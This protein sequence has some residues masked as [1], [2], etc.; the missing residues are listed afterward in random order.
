[1]KKILKISKLICCF[2]LLFMLTILLVPEKAANA[3][4]VEMQ[5]ISYQDILKMSTAMDM[6][7]DSEFYDFG[8]NPYR[9]FDVENKEFYKLF[10][11]PLIS[12]FR[13]ISF[14]GKSK[15]DISLMYNSEREHNTGL[16]VDIP[17]YEVKGNI[18][19]NFK[20]NIASDITTINEEY[21]EYF[22]RYQQTRLITT[23]WLSKDLTSFFT[24][25]FV[26]DL[27]AV[28][29]VNSAISFL[30][31]YGTHVFDSYNLG[32]SLIITN[33]IVSEISIAEEYES[34][35][36]KI[37]LEANIEEAISVNENG[38]NSELEGKNVSTETTKSKMNMRARGGMDFNALTVNDLFTFKQE[39][40]TGGG[41]GFIYSEWI[42]SFKNSPREVVINAE[43]PVAIWDLL[44]KSAYYDP[45]REYYFEQAFDIMCYGNYSE[46]CNEIGRNSEMIGNIEYVANGSTVQFEVTSD[47]IKLP[48][49]II[50]TF[51]LG[52][53]I[54]NNGNVDEVQIKLDKEYEYAE[55]DG[56][57]INIDSS[58]SGKSVILLILL[59]DEVIYELKIA[60]IDNESSYANGYGTKDQPYLIAT[61]EQWKTFIQGKDTYDKTKKRVYYELA[62]DIDLKGN[63]Y[64][65]GG[66]AFN[67][68]FKGVLDGSNYIISNF[69]IIA[70]S[71][72][73]NVGIIGSNQ[74]V[75]KNIRFDNVKILNSNILTAKNT[76]INAGV[77]VG[78]NVG[79]IYNVIITNSSLKVTSQL[80]NASINAGIVCGY[81][82]GEIS[83][84][85]I[86]NCNIYGQSWKGE[87]AVNIGGLVG[88]V[89]LTEV[90]NCYIN[91][92]NINAFNYK[93]KKAKCSMGGIVGFIESGE[94]KTA[95]ISYCIAYKNELNK[96]TNEWGYIGGI[97]SEKISF[98]NCYFEAFNNIAVNNKP[99][100][101]CTLLKNMTLAN[102]GD[103]EFNKNWTTD[104]NGNVIVKMH[105]KEA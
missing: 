93:S 10:L 37:G 40:A 88:K 12:D 79:I 34:H 25:A 72:M 74:G 42:K 23:D 27:E 91:N 105:D 70:S 102:I 62:N 35:N 1:M 51:N 100:S 49:N 57:Q 73:D 15:E 80:T 26:S 20:T 71:K 22:E 103:A 48:S 78:Y 96:E 13:N 29:S 87:G 52:Q 83:F 38:V 104:A 94:T 47:T 54:I 17:I 95:K 53:T 14:S 41:S 55:I 33:Y 61:P 18:D 63:H 39:Y 5:E 24:E 43:K 75:I 84:V 90:S 85:G 76:E 60:I 86:S 68:S 19:L 89:Y 2:C 64:E 99:M 9:I 6:S 16:D 31:K 8:S 45:T 82:V 32:G 98:N 65:V 101:G 4:E 36:I 46:L 67:E 97:S 30:E 28:K 66:A 44:D 11:S 7:T 92:T 81:S 69:S 59:Q 3:A 77:L 21:F 56:N 50:A 58:A